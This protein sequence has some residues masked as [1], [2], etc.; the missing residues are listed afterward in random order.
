MPALGKVVKW[1][2]LFV[3]VLALILGLLVAGPSSVGLFVGKLSGNLIYGIG[4]SLIAPIAG[5][6]NPETKRTR[7]ITLDILN[8]HDTVK[9]IT[10]ETESRVTFEETERYGWLSTIVGERK[11]TLEANVTYVY[12]IDV[13]EIKPEHVSISDTTVVV[14]LP[15]L[16][17]LYVIPDLDS[18]QYR[19]G[20]SLINRLVDQVHDLSLKREIYT[21]LQTDARRIARKRNLEPDR[22]DVFRDLENTLGPLIA[23][24]TGRSVTF[25]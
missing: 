17:P 24:K 18:I 9:L 15:P 10:R 4:E 11:G 14:E 13:E 6:L 21:T 19:S 25:K 8:S 22:E 12:G 2:I 3:V 5:S 1:S 20:S 16:R 7:S 23:E